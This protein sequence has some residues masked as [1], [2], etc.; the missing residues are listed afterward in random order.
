VY[1][2][3]ILYPRNICSYL[4]IRNFLD[5]KEAFI[6]LMP[7]RNVALNFVGIGV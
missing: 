3:S 4:S 6:D 1:Q 2:I 5:K 7:L